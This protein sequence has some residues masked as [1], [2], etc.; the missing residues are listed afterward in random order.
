MDKA[1]PT[2]SLINIEVNK[3]NSNSI[4]VVLLYS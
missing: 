3:V 1:E 4:V 2:I